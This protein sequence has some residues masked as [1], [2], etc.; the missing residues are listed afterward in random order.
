MPGHGCYNPA[1]NSA[2]TEIQPAEGGPAAPEPQLRFRRRH[3]YAALIPLAFAT[4]LA[5]GFLF[6]GR[7]SPTPPPLAAAQPTAVATPT[8]LNVGTDD[9]PSIGPADAPITIVEFSDFNCPY[10][11]KWQ[12]ETL[13]PLL[14]AYPNQI[15][16]V[17][18]DFPITSQESAIASQAADCAGE[19]G[20][21]WKF[22]DALLG[23]EY[24]LGSDA[25]RA[26]SQELGLNVD[27][28]E[29]C[30]ASG[31]FAQ[32][33]E[34]DARYAAGLGVTGTPTFFVNG[35]P[36]VGAQSLASF[37]QVIDAELKR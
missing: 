7:I 6:W 30:V 16:F 19:Q 9:D 23:G 36:I 33:V 5:T 4:G 29:A 26:Y 10:C 37:R 32:E 8:R 2:G 11:K 24:T 31:K 20:A 21:Y 25:Y 13:Y 35:L 34:A 28:L 12:R 3:V 14:A 17:Y 15:R 22:H 18:R 27:A 1:M